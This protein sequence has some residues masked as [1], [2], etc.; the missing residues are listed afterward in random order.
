MH[1]DVAAKPL[2]QGSSIGV[3]ERNVVRTRDRLERVVSSLIESYCQP[4]LVQRLVRGREFTVP[5]AGNGSTAFIQ[6][7]VLLI[8]GNR[9]LGEKIY[10]TE[11]RGS[12]RHRVSRE[13]P[14]KDDAPIPD[15]L[16]EQC[17]TLFGA[18]GLRDYALLK[19]YL[20]TGFRN[21]ELRT[22]RWGDLQLE[23]DRVYC[24]WR[25]KGSKTD[26]VEFPWPAYHAITDFLQAAGRWEPFQDY[27]NLCYP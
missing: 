1:A 26:L 12:A 16:G 13:P 21:S 19:S 2:H 5:F 10:S 27:N 23:G 18:L 7:L 15:D 20:L 14:T 25:G 6:P 22:L 17:E 3:S 8:D 9:H 4:V 24:R 11:I